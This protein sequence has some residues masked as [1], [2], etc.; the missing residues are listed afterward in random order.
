MQ[1][2]YHDVIIVGSGLAG[3]RAAV[4]VAGKHDVAVLSKLH[5][6]RSH[7]G[8]A[9][10]GISA[11]LGNAE[12]DSPEWH[13]YDTIKGSDYLADQYAVE[14]MCNDA[15]RA[16]I[17]LEHLG[18]PFSRFED[19]RIAQRPF[20]GHTSN[21]GKAPVRRTCY[22][23]D[24]TGHVCLHT[25]YEQSLRKG[26]SFYDE[27]QVLDLCM[28]EGAVNGIV[29][30][31]IKTGQLMLFHARAVM[32]ATG[33]YGK[34]W[35]TTSN[36]FANTGDGLGIA[37]NN[38]M[39]LED[40]EFVQFH[41]TG[42]YRLGILITE[43]AR[44]EGG[45]LRNGQ[46]ER[47]MERY[48]PSIK[49]L[50]PRDIVSRSIYE[51]IR[52]G[53]GAGPMKDHVLLD[54][55]GLSKEKI[56][57]KLPEIESFAKIYLGVDPAEKPIPVQ[58]TCHYA[59]GGIPTDANG[60]VSGD[61]EGREVPGFWAAGEVACVSVHG[62]N[63]LGSNSLLDL[64]VF[65]RR[66]GKDI[67]RYLDRICLTPI[68]LDT[69]AAARMSE[70][71]AVLKGRDGGEAITPIRAELQNVMMENVS[72]FRHE[73][74]LSE[75]VEKITALQKRAE[76]IRVF[77]Q[78]EKFNTELLEA[79]ELQHMVNYSKAVAV[80]ALERRETRGAHS[81][82]DYQSRDDASW[83]KHSI[84][85]LEEGGAITHMQKTVDLSL[86][87]SRAEFVPKERKY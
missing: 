32:F 3:L 43:A 5:P 15:P 19:G 76:A 55:T 75:A 80:S 52:Q 59:M 61:A 87:S 68:P 13:A 50:A 21:F 20:G 54:L 51:E 25:L 7:S 64:I 62:A 45:I 84:C 82:D 65:G 11:A 60:R 31:E 46:G 30:I 9:Q 2:V 22:A 35:R 53:R 74:G 10:G 73:Q 47:F 48:A 12:K 42:L 34:A 67:N 8:A 78:S 38:G 70:K 14:V 58:P 57:E 56:V 49:D 66:A 85:F 71:I 63:R 27:Y 24:R 6:L 17:E 16:I 29:A 4:E 37:L 69:G 18:V 1:V 86:A 44:G 72:V 33:G 41:P 36:A 40:M 79:I 39:P 28:A 81:R 77:D 26:V 23:A 83:L